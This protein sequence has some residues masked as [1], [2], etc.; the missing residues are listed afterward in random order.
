MSSVWHGLCLLY[1]S[2]LEAA[3]VYH[4]FTHRD[5]KDKCA[6]KVLKDKRGK[7]VSSDQEG[8]TLHGEVA[9]LFPLVKYYF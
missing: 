9:K 6:A 3:G 8:S 1:T 2:C 4:G 5:D 7:E